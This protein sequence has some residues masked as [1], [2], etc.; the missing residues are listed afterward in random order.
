MSKGGKID[1]YLDCNS[2]WSYFAYLYLRKNRASLQAHNIS[3]T[4]HPIFLGG[5]NVGSGNKPPGLSPP[6]PPSAH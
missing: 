3:I 1:V 5:I 2:P 4:M 6:K